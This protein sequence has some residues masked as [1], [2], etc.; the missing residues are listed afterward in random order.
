M[1]KSELVANY[2]SVSVLLSSVGFYIYIEFIIV[3]EFEIEA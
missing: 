1:L 2:A 3:N